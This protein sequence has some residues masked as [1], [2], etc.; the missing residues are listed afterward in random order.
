[1][2]DCKNCIW[3]DQCGQEEPCEYY[4]TANTADKLTIKSYNRD[5]EL[6]DLV[7]RSVI[8]ELDG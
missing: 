3:F 5:M 2:R 4:E 7:Y 6:R 8:D 1:M